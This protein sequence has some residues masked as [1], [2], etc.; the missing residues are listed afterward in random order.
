MSLV[1]EV[2]KGIRDDRKLSEKESE[3]MTRLLDSYN[4]IA[5]DNDHIPNLTDDSTGAD[6]KAGI[7]KASPPQQVEL[8]RDYLINTHALT[9]VATPED[10]DKAEKRR[11]RSWLIRFSAIAGFVL[12]F[13]LIGA[14]SVVGYRAGAFDNAVISTLM[15]TATE[16]IKL[17][18]TNSN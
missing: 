7:A 17:W 12:T 10:P 6:L 3:A 8:L 5:K 14:I 16:I 9:G 1:E 18:Y 11:L 4:E 15:N 2:L 13:I